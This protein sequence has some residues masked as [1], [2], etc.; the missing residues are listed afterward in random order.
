LEVDLKE[1]YQTCNISLYLGPLA[2]QDEVNHC[3]GGCPRAFFGGVELLRHLHGD[4]VNKQIP[5]MHM[6][7]GAYKGP[8]ETPPNEPVVFI[9]DCAAWEGTL[10]KKA[11]K[12]KSLF[13]TCSKRDPRTVKHKSPLHILAQVRRGLKHL[14]KHGWTHLPGCPVF[15]IEST[16]FLAKLANLD[17]PAPK[18]M[19][20]SYLKTNAHVA[21]RR[22][23]G[24][25]Y[26]LTDP[27]DRGGAQP[28]W[29]DQQ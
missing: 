19:V 12:V 3:I 2:D 17:T 29:E 4:I 10:N 24:Q 21:M 28:E 23:M 13:K 22:L 5:K 15:F 25:S 16:A 9:G 8:I 20:S 26:H 6:V 14:E 18:G 27:G 7:M 1:Q 11:V